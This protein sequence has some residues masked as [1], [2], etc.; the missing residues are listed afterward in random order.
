MIMPWEE[1]IDYHNTATA[2]VKGTEMKYKIGDRVMLSSKAQRINIYMI[3]EVDNTSDYP[4]KIMLNGVTVG[5]LAENE[6]IPA[7]NLIAPEEAA[8]Q[9]AKDLESGFYDE[10]IGITPEMMGAVVK[11]GEWHEEDS[12][13]DKFI[14]AGRS[15]NQGLEEGRDEAWEAVN[16]IMK[17]PIP[18]R[19][20][21]FGIPYDK[22]YIE[23]ISD[24]FTA[25][26]AIGKLE[27]YQEK[28]N[29]TNVG[30]EVIDREGKR[31]VV[32]EINENFES[33]LYANG[34]SYGVY[35]GR[36]RKTGR[37]FDQI[38]EVLEQMKEE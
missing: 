20:E 1:N 38:S 6:L 19:A 33:V 26:E 25:S 22:A 3:A 27:A 34:H 11:G 28:Q 23:D 21:I 31:G 9:F 16:R 24:K 4:Y 12:T 7:E 30:D 37:H 18:E 36:L 32:T 15:Y 35:G 5:W 17:I 14:V 2:Y 13:T 10:P 29:R 8:E